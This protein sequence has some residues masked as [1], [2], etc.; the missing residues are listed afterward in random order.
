MSI[1]CNEIKIKTIDTMSINQLAFPPTHHSSPMCRRLLYQVFT[2]VRVSMSLYQ[3]ED[4]PIVFLLL[5][6][7]V[8]KYK[9]PQKNTFISLY[10]LRGI[11]PK[12]NWCVKGHGSWAKTV[13]K[14]SK[15]KK[16]PRLSGLKAIIVVIS[17]P[18]R[19]KASGQGGCHE[20]CY[21]RQQNAFRLQNK[22]LYS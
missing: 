6:Y 17:Y 3:D 1:H 14:Q 8:H 15:L 13:I 5:R 18:L 12:Y 20:T 4:W 2:S 22:N 19:G 21:W 7:C 11:F 16:S 10:T 9:W